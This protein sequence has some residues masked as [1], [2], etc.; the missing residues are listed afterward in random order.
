MEAV[1][2]RH[3][4]ITPDVRERAQDLSCALFDAQ[5]HFL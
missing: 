4:E 2:D 1:L 3:I 5:I